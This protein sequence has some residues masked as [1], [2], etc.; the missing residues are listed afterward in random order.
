M[1]SLPPSKCCATATLHSGSAIGKF[2]D[3]HLANLAAYETGDSSSKKIIVIATDIF[4]HKF[5]NTNLVADEFGRNGFYVLIPDILDGD[6]FDPEGFTMEKLQAWFKNHTDDITLPRYHAY[7]EA[8]QKKFPDAK[9]FSV[10]Y[11]FGAPCVISEL[12]KDGLLTAGAVA[13]PTNVQV[14]LVE[15]LEKPLLISAAQTDLLF[16]P[17]L[18]RKTEEILIANNA[19]F[20]IDLFSGV[21][22]GFSIKGDTSI[23]A[24]KYAKEKCFYDINCW[25]NRFA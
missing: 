17:E 23:P 12:T 25:F 19:T 7:L 15:K 1:A 5:L 3:S 9:L 14:S 21:E 18:R 4:G 2:H 22:H 20:Q 11:C 8:V 13:H 6:A 24:V 16:T 10:G